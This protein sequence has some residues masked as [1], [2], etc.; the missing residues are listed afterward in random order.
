MLLVYR[1]R[2][3][4]RKIALK[5]KE[6]HNY[7]SREPF[8]ELTAFLFLSMNN[9]VEELAGKFVHDV[10]LRYFLGNGEEKRID[11]LQPLLRNI[12][13]FFLIFHS[14]PEKSKLETSVSCSQK[15]HQRISDAKNTKNSVHR[16]RKISDIIS[17][18][19]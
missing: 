14:F 1:V 9:F 18:R 3:S 15:S 13:P 8:Y 2:I 6:K 10:D 16:Y 17:E 19:W 12:S 11:I 7:Y 5:E 4:I